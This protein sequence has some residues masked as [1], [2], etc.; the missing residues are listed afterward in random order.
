MNFPIAYDTFG[1]AEHDAVAECFARGQ[2][3]MGDKVREFEV[4]FA[5]YVGVSHAIM[6]NSGSSADLVMMLAARETGLLY[7]GDEILMPAVTWPTQ[8]WAAIE[9]GFQ[10]RLVDVDPTTLNMSPASLK[11][12]IAGN[13]QALFVTHIMGNPSTVREDDLVMFHD[14]CEALGARIDDKHVGSVGHASAFSFFHSHHISTME[15]GMIATNSQLFAECCR[16]LRAHGW[17]RDLQNPPKVQGDKRFHFTGRGFNFRPTELNGAIGL[18]QLARLEE[19]NRWR[20][21]HAETLRTKIR[22]EHGNPV[23]LI[24]QESHTVKPSWFAMPFVL[25]EDLP[26]SRD[27]VFAYLNEHGI[28]SRPMLGG[29]LARQPAFARL[30]TLAAATLQNADDIQARG[31][32]IGLPPFEQVMSP[33]VNAFQGMHAAL[34]NKRVMV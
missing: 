11:Q 17:I 13:T 28:E 3:T 14:C 31:F 15:G 6:V 4:K 27:E 16:Q 30:S 18:V 20:N 26:Y 5:E 2:T 34:T 10:V 7:V 24:E 23:R 25:K 1:K 19:F 32:Y 12:A 22:P 8:A 33:V 29:N 21:H 9:A